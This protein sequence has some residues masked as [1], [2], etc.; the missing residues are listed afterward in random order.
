MVKSYQRF[1][2]ANVFGVI[3]SNSNSVWIEPEASKRKTGNLGQVIVGG[4]ENI[5][6][7]DIKTGEQIAQLTDGLPPGASDAKLSKPAETT[8][9]KYHPETNL[10]A[11]GYADGVIKIWDLISKTVLI[12]FN[13]HKSAITVLAFD[14]TG[15]RLI[16]AS[17]DSDI[18]VWDL[19]GESGLYKLR[20]H[21]DAITGLWCEDE[22]WLISTSKDGLVKIWDLKSQQCVETHLAHTGECWSLGIIEDMAVTCSADSQVKLWKLDL[23]AENG[24]KLTEKGIIEKQSKQRGVEIDFAVAPDGVKFFYIQNADKTIE[25]YR[26]RKEEEISRALKKR[27]KRLQDKGMS[28]EEIKEAMG[29][30]VSLMYHLFQVVRSPY[31]IKSAQWTVCSNSKLELVVTTSNNSIEYYSIPY[32]KREPTQ[33]APLK[34]HTI[35]LHGQRTDIRSTSISDDNKLL[36]TASNGSLKIWNI[37]TK[38]C[39]RSFEC[40][41]AL[42]CKFLPGGALVV[43]GTRN[44]ELQLFDIAS[45]TMLDNKEGAHDAAIWSLDLTS[46]GRKLV[47]GS[48]DKTVRFWTFEVSEGPVSDESNKTMPMLQLF[49]DTTLE[50]DDDILSVVISPDDKFIAVSLLD[51]TV[52]VFFL[53]SMK[54]FLSLYGH[55]LPVLSMDIS[56]DSK[57]IV[58]CSADKNIKIWGLDFGDCHKSLFAHQDSIMN[59]KFLPESYNF[60]SCSKDATVKYWDGQKFECIQKLAAHQSEVW[61]ISVS[62][63]GT[64]VISTGHDHSIRVWEETEDQVFLEEEREKEMDEQYEDTLLTSLEGGA[65]DE[66]LSVKKGDNEESEEVEGVHKQTVESLKAGERLM[67]ALEIGVNDIIA[68]E[69]FNEQLNAWKKSKKGIQ[70][71]RPQENTLLVAL[72]KTPEEY[73]IETLVKIKPSQIED[74]L[75]VMPFSYILKFL[76]FIDVVTT[77]AALLQKHISLVCKTLFFVIRFNYKELVAQKNANLK[78]Q[79]TRVKDN[80]R[81]S[82]KSNVDELGFNIEGM[83]FIKQQWELN[84]HLEFNDEYEEKNFEEKHSKKRVFGTLA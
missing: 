50:L 78:L 61:S 69:E 62:N 34:L 38:R 65:G 53:D 31:K 59:V 72:K 75:M 32:S 23:Q 68:M 37:K 35:D 13:G 66:M 1:E 49:H 27:E 67:E 42:T 26:L 57:L 8:F 16:S 22:N 83:K 12:S 64:F 14:T 58:T 25:I 21:K 30:P 46:D 10:L 29:S 3:S 43:V 48:A 79:I 56:Y 73:I 11:A 6:V 74:A 44:G 19:V 71:I 7:W 18:I 51:N 45:S 77:K 41:Y 81:K 5:L 20:S 52:K 70:P 76:K 2:Q 9:L 33:P 24:S 15:T 40:G 28:E 84:H 47:T 55:K 39:I 60:F 82:L 54:F 80:L 17:K 36:A 4:L 63:D